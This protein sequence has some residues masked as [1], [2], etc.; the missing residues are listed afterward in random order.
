ILVDSALSGGG[1]KNAKNSPPE[2]VIPPS[3]ETPTPVITPPNPVVAPPTPVAPPVDRTPPQ[4]VEKESPPLQR[5]SPRL[6]NTPR[7]DPT[8]VKPAPHKPHEI[9]V[10]TTLVTSSAADLKAKQKAQ[11]RAAELAEQQRRAGINSVFK[12]ATTGIRGG[13]SGSTEIKL[14]GP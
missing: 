13:I 6:D 12:N 9:N 14:R 3:P 5:E 11:Q 2:G 4:R 8:P 10:D 7:V 1:D